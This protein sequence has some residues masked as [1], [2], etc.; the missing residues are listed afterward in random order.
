[1][2]KNNLVKIFTLSLVYL[3]ASCNS[4]STGGVTPF[5]TGEN[6]KADGYKLTQAVVLSR[7]N[8]RSP[9]SGPG[10]ILNRLTYSSKKSPTA[11][12]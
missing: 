10:S 2:R 7:H 1:M 11:I 6:I 3:L 5:D 8:I 12:C 9:L 4:T